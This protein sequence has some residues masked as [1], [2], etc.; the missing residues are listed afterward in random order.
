M[1]IMGNTPILTWEL[2]PD[3]TAAIIAL[4]IVYF[5]LLLS[6]LLGVIGSQIARWWRSR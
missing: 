5:V 2:P 6:F 4:V 3:V 1:G